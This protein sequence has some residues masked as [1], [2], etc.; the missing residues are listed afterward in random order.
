MADLPEEAVAF[1]FSDLAGSSRLLAAPPDAYRAAVARRH[2]LLWGAVQAHGGPIFETVG[3]ALAGDVAGQA[4]RSGRTGAPRGHCGS[5]RR[6]SA[7]GW[8]PPRG[9][10]CGCDRTVRSR[11]T[12]PPGGVGY[13]W[14]LSA[15]GVG[16]PSTRMVRAMAPRRRSSSHTV[17]PRGCET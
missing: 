15:S 10:P 3:D 13:A 7:A 1:Q 12:R 2:A 9:R 6:P 8:P 4:A 16:R 5:R 14:P 17:S 11:P